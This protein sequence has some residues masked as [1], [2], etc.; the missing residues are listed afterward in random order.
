MLQIR[1][2]GLIPSQ[3]NTSTLLWPESQNALIELI[4]ALYVTGSIGRG[5][6]EIRK[7]AIVFQELFQIPL[8]DIHHAFHR[9]KTRAKSRTWYLDRLKQELE[10]YMDRDI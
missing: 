4:Y 9:M 8:G 5:R 10:E 1:L 6:I 2:K 7:I 3:V